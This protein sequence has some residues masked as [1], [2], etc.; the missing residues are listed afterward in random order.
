MNTCLLLALVAIRPRRDGG[1]R[2][3]VTVLTQ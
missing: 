3:V 1:Y 2:R